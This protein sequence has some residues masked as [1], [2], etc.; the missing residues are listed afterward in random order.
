MTQKNFLILMILIGVACALPFLVSSYRTFQAHA[1]CWCTP[2]RCSWLNILHRIQ[3]ADSPSGHERLL[4]PGRLLRRDPHRQGGRADWAVVPAA[5]ASMPRRRVSCSR[6]PALRL[7]GLSRARTFALGVARWPQL[8]EST[9]TSKV[10][11]RRL[12]AIVIAKPEAPL[13]NS[14]GGGQVA[15]TSSLLGV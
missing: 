13:R 14:A 12:Q 10:D 6:L 15:A 1:G 4:R 11:R 3:R 8:P 5:A 9:I 2:S 7:E